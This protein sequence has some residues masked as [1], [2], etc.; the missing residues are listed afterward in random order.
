MN[1]QLRDDQIEVLDRVD[2]TFQ[3][4]RGVLLILPVGFGKTV[5]ALEHVR[6]THASALVIGPA[7]LK[8]HW[9]HHAELMK[10]T[11]RFVSFAWMAR[12]SVV[13]LAS[14]SLKY[15]VII[16]DEAHLLRNSRTKRYRAIAKL[17]GDS[18]WLLLS[19]TPVVTSTNNPVAACALFDPVAAEV[20]FGRSS[21]SR[22]DNERAV[23]RLVV[24]AISSMKSSRRTPV[25]VEARLVPT[26]S[27]ADSCEMLVRHAIP[28]RCLRPFYLRLV[29]RAVAS[30][31]GA[32][33][34]VVRS[35]LSL[36]DRSD[37][38]A[39]SG[40]A[41]SRR[42]F[43]ATFGASFRDGARFQGV[44]PW[45]YRSGDLEEPICFEGCD[46]DA[47]TEAAARLYD[48]AREH[49][50]AAQFARD[51]AALHPAL[52]YS[53]FAA[54]VWDLRSLLPRVDVRFVDANR[55]WSSRSGSRSSKSWEVAEA[56]G[57]T[58]VTTDVLSVGVGLPWIRSVVHLE[59][60]RTAALLL[61]R[62]GRSTRSPGARLKRSV[63]FQSDSTA[64]RDVSRHLAARRTASTEFLSA[65]DC[66]RATAARRTSLMRRQPVFHVKHQSV[67]I[68]V[69]RAIDALKAG[70]DVEL[71]SAIEDWIAD[72]W[73][74][75]LEKTAS[76]RSDHLMDSDSSRSKARRRG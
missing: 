3:R 27:I 62:E 2:V 73:L 75:A 56:V 47:V 46:R 11:I 60:P 31:A 40:R 19:A 74:T 26:A 58:V 33:G 29:D 61:Q 44:F 30:S 63:R 5:V 57:A 52:V 21:P 34:A 13:E 45:M 65:M 12:R 50:G 16:V 25:S 64:G 32:I 8:S 18:C 76:F 49:S 1:L 38:A 36:R 68:E 41:I 22:L 15:P 4:E 42:E 20:H 71:T 51:H 37:E 14:E 72:D 53:D 69:R 48:F 17:G 66:P 28:E 39:E 7:R 54:S 24:A 59:E 6:R 9:A 70:G 35:C 43:Y 23:S 10:V 55:V 67:G